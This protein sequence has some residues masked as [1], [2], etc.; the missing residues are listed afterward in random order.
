MVVQR[1]RKTYGSDHFVISVPDDYTALQ[2]QLVVYISYPERKEKLPPISSDYENSKR[3]IHNITDNFTTSEINNPNDLDMADDAEGETIGKITSTIENSFRKFPLNYSSEE[4]NAPKLR[5]QYFL[6]LYST[7][8][9]K[10]L[11]K[12]K[13]P[14]DMSQTGFVFPCGVV[15]HGGQHIVRNNIF[16]YE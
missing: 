11:K 9:N 2:G 6:S 1:V 8:S 16:K 12:Y 4:G 14:R 7:H 5:Q 13:I 10:P 15:V 3:E